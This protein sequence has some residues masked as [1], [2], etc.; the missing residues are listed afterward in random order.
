M[1]RLWIFG[2]GNEGELG[3]KS[4]KNFIK[5]PECLSKNIIKYRLMKFEQVSCG[6]DYVFAITCNSNL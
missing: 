3:N 6:I 2:F 1:D 4:S 5:K